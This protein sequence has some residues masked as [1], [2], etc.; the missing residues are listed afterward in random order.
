MAVITSDLVVLD[1]GNEA[2]TLSVMG[3][4]PQTYFSSEIILVLNLY[5]YD[6]KN[7]YFY[8]SLRPAVRLPRS[9]CLGRCSFTVYRPTP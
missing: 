7:F 4:R 2:S 8:L 1:I 9:I 5:Y 6:H 3:A